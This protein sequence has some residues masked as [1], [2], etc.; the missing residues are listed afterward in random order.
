M[1]EIT[2]CLPQKAIWRPTLEMYLCPIPFKIDT[3]STNVHVLY[4]QY[5]TM[6]EHRLNEEFRSWLTITYDQPSIS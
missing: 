6:D 3:I 5:R 2:L 4:E 1:P